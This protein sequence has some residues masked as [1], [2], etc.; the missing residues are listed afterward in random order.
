MLSNYTFPFVRSPFCPIT[1]SL[2]LSLISHFSF[3]FVFFSVFIVLVT[4]LSASLA[5]LIIEIFSPRYSI[6]DDSRESAYDRNE[7]NDEADAG[8]GGVFESI[9]AD[10]WLVLPWLVL[11]AFVPLSP[12]M[13]SFSSLPSVQSLVPSHFHGAGRQCTKTK[14]QL[15]REKMKICLCLTRS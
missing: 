11:V 7:E 8:G 9:F 3:L 6:C 12:H 4:F 13:S 5:S 14:L 2:R 1:L 10:V 15:F